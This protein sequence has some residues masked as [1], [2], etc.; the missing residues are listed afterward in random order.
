MEK[1]IIVDDERST[2]RGL[3]VCMDWAKYGI[4]VAGEAENGRKGLELA[5]ALQPDIVLTDVRMPVMDGIEMTGRLRA[6]LPEVKVVFVSGYDEVDYLKTAM[7][8]DAVDYILKPVHLPELTE[9]VEKIV[10]L[11]HRERGRRDLLQRMSARLHES[12]PLLRERFFV[13]LIRGGE[14]GGEH[15]GAAL[16]RRAAFLELGLACE[17]SYAVLLVSID[18]SQAVFEAMPEREAELVS[19]AVCNICQ[20]VLEAEQAGFVFEHRRGEYVLAVQLGERGGIE[21]LVPLAE[22]LKADLSGSLGRLAGGISLTIG[23]GGVASG[24]GQLHA[25]YAMAY[26]AIAHKL[27]LGRNRV[28]AFDAL[29]SERAV[30]F[31]GWHARIAELAA[32]LKSADRSALQAQLSETFAALA[33]ERTIGYKDSQRICLQLLLKI[34]EFVAEFGFGTEAL[35]RREAEAWARVAQLETLE[36]MQCELLG[37]LEAV[38]DAVERRKRTRSHE[39]VRSIVQIVESEY[40]GNLTIADIAAKVYLSQTYICLLFKQETGETINEYITRVRMHKAQELLRDTDLKLAEVCFAIGYAEPSYFSKQ[41]RKWA[42][43]N[44]REYRDTYR[45]D[46]G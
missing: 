35:S 19:F 37:L 29:G 7:K 24:L 41:F 27:Y 12:M 38:C 30:D 46:R 33:A 4:E 40:G 10:T 36:D 22:R 5:E 11:T 25:S 2:R 42:G 26:E 18:N 17:A 16:G 20:E 15:D 8:M 14:S 13:Q 32:L 28:I 45:E 21:S 1:L 31:G 9:V 43:M 39:A 44:P 34:S 23:I 3:R 6:L